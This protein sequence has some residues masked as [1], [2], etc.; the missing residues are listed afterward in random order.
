MGM[1]AANL[2]YASDFADRFRAAGDEVGAPFAPSTSSGFA[3]A[4]SSVDPFAPKGR[5]HRTGSGGDPFPS[6]TVAT[7]ISA[8]T[9]TGKEMTPLG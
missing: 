3:A 1:E 9:L 2:E 7:P 6:R 5:R 4:R 8:R